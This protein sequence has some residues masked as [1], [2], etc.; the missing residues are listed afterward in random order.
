MKFKDPINVLCVEDEPEQLTLR[1]MLF[2]SAGFGFRGARSGKQALELFANPEI[3]AVVMD[4]WMSGM[5]GLALAGEMKRLR[6]EIPIIMLSGFASLPGEGAGTVD[7]W[8]QKARTEP[9][10]LVER[11]RALAERKKSRPEVKT[12]STPSVKASSKLAAQGDP[13]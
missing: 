12:E 9:E 2:E 1:Q 6:P 13:I 4:Y 11:V 10:A 5:N 7:A 8:L 3:S